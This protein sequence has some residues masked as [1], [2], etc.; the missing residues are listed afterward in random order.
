MVVAFPSLETTLRDIPTSLPPFN[1]VVVYVFAST[2]LLAYISA[3]AGTPVPVIGVALPSRL[4]VYEYENLL[5]SAAI[6]SKPTLI[7][8]P[9]AA[10]VRVSLFSAG[11]PVNFD[12][13]VFNFQVPTK[14]TS[15]AS[16]IADE[17][18]IN[19][20]IA[21]TLRVLLKDWMW[22]I[23]WPRGTGKGPPK[24]GGTL[25][26]VIHDV[27]R[28]SLQSTA[29]ACASL[30]D[31]VALRGHEIIPGNWELNTEGTEA[32]GAQRLAGQNSR[33]A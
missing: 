24:T 20:T 5:P 30:Q 16:N 8:L 18:I 1:H 14:G 11:M 17:S 22:C 4:V 26:F 33:R 7:P 2:R 10:T 13:A 31:C 6:P 25:C 32:R 9:C 15:W 21:M 28:Q 19:D 29:L 3:P 12:L 27:K 23:A